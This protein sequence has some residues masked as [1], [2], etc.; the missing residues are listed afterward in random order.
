[1][2]HCE[3][4]SVESGRLSDTEGEEEAMVLSFSDILKVN[5]KFEKQ[6]SKKNKPSWL[7]VSIS[8]LVCS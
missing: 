5:E 1:M 3:T 4:H 2:N 7:Q 8:Q 6:M